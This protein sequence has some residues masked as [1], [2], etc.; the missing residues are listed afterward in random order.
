MADKSSV[1]R[2]QAEAHRRALA[3]LLKLDATRRCAECGGRGPTWASVN[4]GIFVCLNCSGTVFFFH[5]FSFAC[6][7]PEASALLTW[8]LLVCSQ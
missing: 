3:A 1:T 5:F 6:S 8:S 7:P 4:L 2:A